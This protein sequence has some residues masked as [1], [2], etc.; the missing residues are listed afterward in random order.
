MSSSTAHRR[1]LVLS[2][3]RT[4]LASNGTFDTLKTL[5][6]AYLFFTRFL[7]ISR[8][9]RARGTVRT[10]HD[11]YAW[12]SQEVVLLVLRF[13]AARRKVNA[14]LDKVR[15]DL[16]DGMVPHGPD[17]VRH[18]ALPEQSQSP[19]WIA[20]EMER[21]DKEGKGHAN[22]AEGRV[23]GA[24]Y[25]G[26]DDL[27]RV[28]LAAIE[29]YALSNPLHP[30]V[31]PAVRKME[32][33]VVAMCLRMY[34]NP[35][36]AG[37]TTSGGTESIV[38]AVKT[39]RDWARAAKGITEPEM[40]VP[41]TAH[42]AFDKGAAYMGV[43]VHTVPVDP[44]TRKADLKRVAR[45]INSNTI[46]LVGS[47]INFPDGN[48]DDIPALGA[49]A[50]KYNVGLHVDCCLGSFIMPFVEEAGFGP[51][52]PFDFR[53]PGVTSI[54]CDTHKYGFAPKGNSVIMYRDAELRRHQ[55]YVN[56]GWV[57]GVYASPSIAGSRPG[58]L[59]AGTW[60]AMHYMGH[61]GYLESCR[62]IVGAARTIAHRIRTEIPE[63]RVLGDPPAS[64]VAFAAAAGVGRL[65]VLEV[66]DK[67][68]KRGWHLNG[69][70]GPAA[71][72]I[73]VTRLTV[74]VV[75]QFIADLKDA[76]RE[77][78]D[79]PEGKGTMVILYG[80]GSSSPV[81]PTIVGHVA[82]AFLDT[83]YKA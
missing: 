2:N 22:W 23:S 32:A 48:Q 76:V 81:G 39:Y 42:A 52:Q 31:F 59:I 75:D 60:A 11:A 37:T 55:Y 9:V 57:G 49:L 13:P 25:H 38:M 45:A 5:I 17:V 33:E 64:V 47:A 72:H 71:V 50:Q 29:R 54:S 34:N 44:I 24:V 3:A 67:M 77:A 21:M 62:A 12:I 41:V 19:D 40:V 18:L 73:A 79:A 66:G 74:P 10:L 83:L 58:A 69:L 70:S 7:K 61:S 80:L 43:K 27:T 53:V 6:V 35:S 51:V 26:G 78:R 15:L 36:G 82:T 14:E 1:A 65:N 16:E 63:L 56:P 4:L 8:H 20:Q 30:S 46:M 68:E 28:I